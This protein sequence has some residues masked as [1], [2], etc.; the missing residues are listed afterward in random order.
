VIRKGVCI[1]NFDVSRLYGIEIFD[2]LTTFAV[3]VGRPI[4]RTE[5]AILSSVIEQTR[6]TYGID[7]WGAG[8]FGVNKKGHLT[9]IS[10]EN[11]NLTADIKEIIDG[12]HK[13]GVST[14][15]CLDF[16]SYFLARSANFKRH[17]RNRSKSS[18]IKAG[19]FAFTR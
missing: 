19:T 9:V 13:R 6:E 7:N 8:Y 3:S 12:L 18:S 17:S 4:N 5:C 1:S 16:R 10:P 11:E 2:T 15:S 14:R